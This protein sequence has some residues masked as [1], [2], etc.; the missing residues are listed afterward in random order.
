MNNTTKTETKALWDYINDVD[1]ALLDVWALPD[2]IGVFIDNYELDTTVDS[3]DK[4]YNL[5]NAAG[6]LYSLLTLVERA[7]WAAEEKKEAA[8][9]EYRKSSEDTAT[10]TE[11]TK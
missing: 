10:P 2:I 9:E 5:G 7:I 1:D 8:Y 3:E 11:T 4:R 6:R